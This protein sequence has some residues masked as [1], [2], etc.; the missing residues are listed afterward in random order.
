[1]KNGAGNGCGTSHIS[2]SIPEVPNNFHTEIL[3]NEVEAHLI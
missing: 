2:I 3:Y 1:M